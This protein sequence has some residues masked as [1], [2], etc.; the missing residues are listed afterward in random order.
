MESDGYIVYKFYEGDRVYKPTDK[1]FKKMKIKSVPTIVVF[2]V[3]KEV[4]RHVGE[5]PYEDVTHLVKKLDEQTEEPWWK[6]K[7]W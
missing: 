2:N 4:R 5:T 7:L 3:G 1:F 6:I